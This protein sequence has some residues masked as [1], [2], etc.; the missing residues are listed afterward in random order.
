MSNFYGNDTDSD[1]DDIKNNGDEIENFILNSIYLDICQN[2][3]SD[4]PLEYSS[5]YLFLSIIPSQ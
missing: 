4:E 2:L 1:S 3:C 5:N